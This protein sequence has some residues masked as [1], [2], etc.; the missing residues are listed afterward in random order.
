MN[1][2]RIRKIFFEFFKK[3]GHHNI[4]SSSLIPT[5]DPTILFTNAGMNQ[6]KDCFLG[7]EKRSYTKAVTIQKCVRAGGKHNDLD[8][9]GF[10]DRHLTFFEMMGNFSFADYFKE[11]A[12]TYAW[13]FLT[14]NIGL[15]P[16]H[17]YISVFHDDLESTAIWKKISGFSDTKIFKLG[18]D[19]NF[20]QMGDVGPC[21]PCTEIFYDRGNSY[22]CSDESLCKK[23]A[24]DCSRYLE[25]WNL[26]F[27]QF[28]RQLDGTLKLLAHPGVDTGMGLERLL[29][30]IENVPSVFL[31]S[32]FAPIIK[33]IEVLS[34]KT[35][36]TE[37]NMT[38]AAFHVLA[39]HIR[40]STFLIADGAIPSNDGRGYVLRKIIRRAILF[41]QKLSH[42]SIFPKLAH[43][44]I[45]TFG[46]IYPELE[47]QK[48][49]I[50]RILET[51]TEKFS[52]NVVRGSAMLEQYFEKMTFQK[53]ISGDEAFKLYDTYGFPLELVVAASKERGYNVDIIAFEQLMKKQKAQ[54]GKKGTD[55]LDLVHPDIETVFTG[56][57]ELNTTSTIMALVHNNSLVERVI[58]GDTCYI[59]PQ[60]SPFFIVGG[61]QVPDTGTIKIHGIELPFDEVRYIDNAIAILVKTPVTLSCG[62]SIEQSVNRE[63][64]IYAMK[65]HTATH[66]LQAALIERFGAGIKQSGSLVH[67][68]YLRFDFTFHGILTDADIQVIESIINQ[69]IQDNIPVTISYTS[70]TNAI[71]EGA[72]AF[73]GDK[74]NTDSVRVVKVGDFSTELC[75]GTHVLQTG[76]IG[77]FKITEIATPASGQRR[78]HAVSGI[79]AVELMQRTFETIKQL[80]QEFKVKKEEVIPAIEKQRDEIKKLQ[81]SVNLH[82]KQLMHFMI[83]ELIKRTQM[84]NGISVGIYSFDHFSLNDLQIMGQFL[85]QK[86]NGMYVLYSMQGDKIVI[87]AITDQ[88][89]KQYIDFSAFK[90]GLEKDIQFRGGTTK[91]GLQGSILNK[92]KIDDKIILDFLKNIIRK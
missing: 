77:L 16:E 27:M 20:W 14:Q 44:V 50:L 83:P 67:P 38:Q 39:D 74:Y 9:V 59:I 81:Q 24:C 65:N 85:L 7:K 30:V 4:S 45:E 48:L 41:S 73:F 10:T 26:V 68:D 12:I 91:D 57:D 21:G 70:L 47:K 34:G 5:Q 40:S 3:H 89:T 80:S 42:Q 60:E 58:E 51:E 49:H 19:S 62:D 13:D 63:K 87:F 37:S 75:G 78:I 28:E 88:S 55:L 25:I 46:K 31:T 15:N 86:Q 53:T 1:S 22:G 66:L 32:L 17:L 92:N 36:A 29:V 71:K 82:K 8:N 64:R 90:S 79:K 6:F 84:I 69:K 33:N 61:G 2:E 52:T 43:S 35:Y 11:D 18:A 56:Y 23:V 76:E 54:S 72:L